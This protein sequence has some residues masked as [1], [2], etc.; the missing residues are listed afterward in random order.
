MEHPCIRAATAVFGLLGN[1][2]QVSQAVAV[3]RD[4]TV[5][6]VMSGI[7]KSMVTFCLAIDLCDSMLLYLC[8]LQKD[9]CMC[10]SSV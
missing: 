9:H 1:A 10:N 4:H 8:I 2:L 5:L 7:W 6:C 3:Y